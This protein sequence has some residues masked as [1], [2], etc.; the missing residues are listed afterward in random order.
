MENRVDEAIIEIDEWLK[1]TGMK[2]SRLGLLACANARAVERVRAGSG[3]VESLRA[4]LDYIAKNP[5][6]KP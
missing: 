2:E 3:S 6:V 4:L 1:R 5:A